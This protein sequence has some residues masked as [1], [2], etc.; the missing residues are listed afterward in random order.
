MYPEGWLIDPRGKFLLFFQKDSGSQSI[1]SKGYV[2]KW[3]ASDGTPTTLKSRK[4]FS[5]DEAISL[6]IQLTEDGWRRVERQFGQR[7]A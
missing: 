2:D 7:A 6:W 4:E 3:N 1:P 5:S